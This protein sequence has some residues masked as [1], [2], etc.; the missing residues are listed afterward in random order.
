M[1]LNARSLPHLSPGRHA[2]GHGL[3]LTVQR[4]GTRSWTQ[5]LRVAGRRLDLGLGRFPDVSLKEARRVAVRNRALAKAGV[6]PRHSTEERMSFATAN[7]EYLRWRRFPE[8]QAGGTRSN[9]RYKWD[10]AMAN[11]VLPA[12]GEVAVAELSTQEVARIASALVATPSAAKFALSCIERV[13]GWAIDSGHR[14]AANPASGPNRQIKVPAHR[15]AAFLPVEEVADALDRIEASGCSLSVALALRFLA[16]TARRLVE[17]RRATWDQI[18]VES[19][20]WTIPGDAETK[21]R[22]DHVVPL[23]DAAL[24]VLER[25]R[26]LGGKGAV[27]PGGSSGGVLADA[28]VRRAMRDAG[29]AASPH[30]FRSTFRTWAQSQ[31]ENWEASE[32]SLGHRIGSS[33]SLSYARSD[34]LALR[35]RLM[36]RY[37][38]ALGSLWKAS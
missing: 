19:A 22:E 33:V 9:Q 21:V 15:H 6:D 8:P 25:A 12:I 10:R 11:H 16:L 30:G 38:E 7:G 29:I 4:R 2:D 35:R 34:M 31:G 17:V 37:S 27:F 28:S 1:T 23:S 20:E 3:Y 18:D 32:L 36:D 24:A 13:C 26:E 5:V 14:E